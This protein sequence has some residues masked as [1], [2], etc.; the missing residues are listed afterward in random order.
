MEYIKNLNLWGEIVDIG[1][2]DGKFAFIGKT[3]NEGRDFGGAKIFPGLVDMHSHG[4]KGVDANAAELKMLSRFYLENGTTT[5]YPTTSTVGFDTLI[6]ACATDTDFEGGANI[7]GFH[8]EGPFIN[9]KYR[10]AQN[11]KYAVDPDFAL[12]EACPKA[13]IITVAPELDGAIEFIKKA[14]AAGVVVCLGHTD[15]DYDTCME[16][17]KAGAKSLTHTCNAM[18]S[19]HHRNP[20]P[21]PAGADAGA[22]AQ[23]ISD[24]YHLHPSIVRMLVKLYGTDRVMLISDSV[25]SAKMPDGEYGLGGRGIFIKDGIIRTLD[26]GV[27]AG[28]SFT[29]YECV[30]SAIS[31]GIPERD[32]FK[33]AAETPS[34]LLGLNKGKIEVGFD[35]DFIIAD[36]NYNIIN[37]AAM[38]K[39]CK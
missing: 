14:S 3:E 8:L 12:I 30:K 31:F 27:L 37:T 7:P 22:F 26:T 11:D 39:F 6:A 10:G 36:E 4:A 25:S 21:I 16:A 15:A 38:G 1:I 32:A 19:I 20:G 23:V 24:G 13:K 18:P 17:F 5:W 34:N 9:K 2:E 35:A 28:S 33:M 29:L